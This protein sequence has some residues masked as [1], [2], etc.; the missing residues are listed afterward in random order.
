VILAEDEA[1]LYLQATL[2]RVWAP[3]G[4]P[5]VVAADP[6]REKTSFYGT[7]NLRTGTEIATQCAT[8]NAEAS[9]RHVEEVLAAHPDVPLLLLWDRAPWHRGAPMREVL[10]AN[11]RLEILPF[12]VAAPELNPQEHIW[13]A[14]REA[15]SH[16]HTEAKL[17]TLAAR[18]EAHL[19]ATTFPTSFLEHRGF[20]TVHPMSNW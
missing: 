19:T 4:Q 9:A 2:R 7:L 16:N 1:T 10:A 3:R 13:K 12:P 18:F 17:S 5:P 14:A 15:V 6:G 11:P 20:Y 8:M